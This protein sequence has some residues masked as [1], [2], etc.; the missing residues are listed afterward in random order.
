[1]SATCTI[2][3]PQSAFGFGLTALLARESFEAEKLAPRIGST[4]GALALSG[5]G[6]LGGLPAGPKTKK[7]GAKL[8]VFL[9]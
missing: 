5:R 7:P 9:Q 1:L 8:Q 4:L 3:N 2:K 6:L